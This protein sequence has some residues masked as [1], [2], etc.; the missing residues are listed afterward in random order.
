MHDALSPPYVT[1]GHMGSWG[2]KCFSSLG[3]HAAIFFSR[4]TRRTKWKRDTRSLWLWRVALLL[5]IAA[6]SR[7]YKKKPLAPRVTLYVSYQTEKYSDPRFWI[8]RAQGLQTWLECLMTARN[9][10]GMKGKVGGFQN[11]GVCL[12]AFPSFPSPSPLFFHT[13]ILCPWTPWKHLLR[14]LTVL[15]QEVHSLKWR[16]KRRNILPLT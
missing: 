1:H 2:E 11:P 8:L 5:T 4:N 14:R 10:S 15:R 3:F 13:V 12:R 9:Q 6:S 16:C 7:K